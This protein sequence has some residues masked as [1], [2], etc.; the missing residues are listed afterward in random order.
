MLIPVSR[1]IFILYSIWSFAAGILFGAVYDV[2]R[3]RRAAFRM[4][5]PDGHGKGRLRRFLYADLSAVD[6]A[7]TFFEDVLFFTFC[8]VTVILINYKLSFGYPR[9]YAAAA[10]VGGFSLYHVTV[11]RL[12]MF[13][14]RAILHA[15]AAFFRFIRKHTVVPLV[16]FFRHISGV[17]RINK[18]KK[19]TKRYEKRMLNAVSFGEREV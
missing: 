5:R 9:W 10:C 15:I 12:V 1:E 3:I 18:A 16:A 13:F 17:C 2:F 14:E 11:G 19:Y 6:T 4:S 7:V 8:A